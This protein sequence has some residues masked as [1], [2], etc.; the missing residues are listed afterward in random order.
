MRAAAVSGGRSTDP[1]GNNAMLFL[2]CEVN[3]WPLRAFV[4]TG[5]QVRVSCSI[6]HHPPPRSMPGASPSTNSRGGG[7]ESST[8]LPGLVNAAEREVG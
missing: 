5:A 3:G 6:R 4:D 1:A 2:E 7:G 8:A